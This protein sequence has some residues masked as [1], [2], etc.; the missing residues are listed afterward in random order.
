MQR[1]MEILIVVSFGDT[2]TVNFEI[3]C[4]GVIGIKKHCHCVITNGDVYV[5]IKEKRDGF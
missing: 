1:V 3:G 2:L 5:R 4:L